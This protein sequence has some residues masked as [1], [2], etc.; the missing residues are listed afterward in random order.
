MLKATVPKRN[1]HASRLNASMVCCP[2]SGGIGLRFAKRP[3]E[4]N[5][6]AAQLLNREH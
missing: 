3:I 1:H 5:E 4:R 6:I 2:C